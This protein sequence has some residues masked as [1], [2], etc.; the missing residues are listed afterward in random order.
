M[1]QL[2]TVV[3]VQ[4]ADYRP[5]PSAHA[6][7][8]RHQT[9]ARWPKFL[10]RFEERA[11]RQKNMNK[12]LLLLMLMVNVIPA[13]GKIADFYLYKMTNNADEIV[14]AKVININKKHNITTVVLLVKETLKGLTKDT[15][16]FQYKLQSPCDISDSKIG[17]SGIYF[18]SK[19][20]GL[21]K[22]NRRLLFAGRGRNPF[23]FKNYDTLIQFNPD[24][25]Y[26]WSIV[27]NSIADTLEQSGLTLTIRSVKYST[28]IKIIKEQVDDT[29]II[30]PK[31]KFIP[32]S[33]NVI[34][35]FI[36]INNITNII[37]KETLY[38][39]TPRIGNSKIVLGFIFGTYNNSEIDSK[40]ILKRMNIYFPFIEFTYSENKLLK[41]EKIDNN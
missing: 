37:D 27:M 9:T 26:P 28:F 12:I 38:D 32:P 18:L 4:R 33:Q 15:I 11:Q 14:T 35:D 16:I 22:L 10:L 17:E 19:Q 36:G 1:Q 8:A 21:N 13:Y 25:V 23:I 3:W 2:A 29:T 40:E 41:I 20:E 30:H 6:L 5:W 39:G 34:D 31:N 7:W 24:V